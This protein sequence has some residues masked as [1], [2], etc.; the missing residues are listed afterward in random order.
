M[1]YNFYIFNKK[2]KCIYYQEW[3][4]QSVPENAEEEQQLIFGFLKAITTFV[5]RTSPVE[6]VL[7]LR[8]QVLFSLPRNVCC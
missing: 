6:Y 2:G 7:V 4:R 5:E 1:I 3:H 8:L